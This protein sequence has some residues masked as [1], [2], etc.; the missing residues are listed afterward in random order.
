VATTVA[1]DRLLALI[2]VLVESVER[3]ARG[4]ELARRAHFSRFHFDRL[5]AA[6]LHET[7]A[8]F[9]RRLLLERAAYELRAAGRPVLHVALDAGYG[10]AE[11]FARAFRRAFGL[12]P[13]EYRARGEPEFRLPAPNGVHFHPPG[14]LLVQAGERSEPM[15]LTDRMLE[16]DLWLTERLIDAAEQLPD[17]ALDEPNSVSPPTP[18][19]FDE[20]PTIRSMLSRLVFTK[21]TWSAALGG[22][23][24]VEDDDASIEGL[25]RRLAASG[26]EFGR[27][28]RQIRERGD[29]DTVFVDATCDPP[30]SFTYGGAIAHAL[31]WNT[32]RRLILALV[33]EQRGVEVEGVDPLGWE[34]RVA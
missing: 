16:H 4:A 31:T 15:D 7:P 18:A 6:A 26:C 3:P 24:F 14:G 11:A 19:F 32:Q 34:R 10:S 22:Y 27:L 8:A 28:V 29:W 33:L 13:S 17:A 30:Q 1:T 2:D 9:R 20:S 23:G 25:R 12:A 5:V 21:E